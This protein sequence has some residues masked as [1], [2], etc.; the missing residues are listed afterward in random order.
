MIPKTR[1]YDNELPSSCDPN[2]AFSSF[3]VSNSFSV[4]WTALT[5]TRFRMVFVGH[6]RIRLRNRPV[7]RWD[8]D[9]GW[10]QRTAPKSRFK[11]TIRS[12]GLA[13]INWAIIASADTPGTAV[14]VCSRP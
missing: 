6:R 11:A 2:V 7:A 8:T 4:Q 12:I 14:D 5:P 1:S 10:D 9:W 13:T 3:R